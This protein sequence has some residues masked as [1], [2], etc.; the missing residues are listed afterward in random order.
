MNPDIM[1]RLEKL[2]MDLSEIED[3]V[4]QAKAQPTPETAFM[5]APQEAPKTLR[6]EYGLG[7]EPVPL[8][9]EDVFAI[10]SASPQSIST[11]GSSD[12]Y[13]FLRGAASEKPKDETA[14]YGDFIRRKIGELMGDISYGAKDL[15]RKG[16][17]MIKAVA[18]EIPS[19]D[20]I[21]RGASELSSII[22]KA[23]PSRKDIE[24]GAGDIARRFPMK[25]PTV[26]DVEYGAKDIGRKVA[27]AASSVMDA[28]PSMSDVEYGVEEISNMV[29]PPA[30][31]TEEKARK[32]TTKDRVENVVMSD[33]ESSD[34]PSLR[35]NLA[36]ARREFDS[37]PKGK[38]NFRIVLDA[39]SKLN[40]AMYSKQ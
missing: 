33:E 37:A 5:T 14:G 19:V 17:G 18:S 34:I 32:Q 2:I 20:D 23:M 38:K 6:M 11:P 7:T 30:V 28:I 9:A 12:I 21:S 1:K 10:K 26:A 16:E 15:G 35:K 22:A 39:L 27:T 4:A 24:Y 31:T 29:M 13:S 25:P 36:M 40:R 3:Q 8:S